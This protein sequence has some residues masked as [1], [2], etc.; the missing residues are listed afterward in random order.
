[1]AAFSAR[2]RPTVITPVFRIKDLRSIRTS[3]WNEDKFIFVFLISQAPS[4]PPPAAATLHSKAILH[5]ELLQQ[6]P[7]Q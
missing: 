2:D 4:S 5:T 1:M 3:L 7:G 6:K